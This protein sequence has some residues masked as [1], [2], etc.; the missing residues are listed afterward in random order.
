M[1][2]AAYLI[3]IALFMLAFGSVTTRPEHQL[4][5]L[6]SSFRLALAQDKDV[7]RLWAS[8]GR[9]LSDP[10]DVRRYRELLV[11]RLCLHDLAYSVKTRPWARG[12]AYERWLADLART[13]GEHDVD[14]VAEELPA[15]VS[16]KLVEYIAVLRK[17]ASAGQAASS[18]PA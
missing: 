7:A 9:G 10:L 11:Q 16:S 2:D 15:A 4:S 17:S 18:P 3:L 8:G 14:L 13:L 1:S 6:T 12:A 5:A